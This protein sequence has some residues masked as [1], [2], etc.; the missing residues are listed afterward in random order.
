MFSSTVLDLATGLVFCFLTASLSTGVVVEAISSITKWRAK[1]LRDGIGQLL[2]DPQLSGLAGQLYS[3]A[4]I[5]PRGPG[6]ADPEKNRPAYIDRQLFAHAMMDLTGIS[7]QVAAAAGASPGARPSLA[8]LHDEVRDKLAEMNV[9][10]PQLNILLRGIIDRS[11]GDAEKIQTELSTWFDHAMDRVSGVYKRY[12]QLIGF[13]VALILAGALNI[14]SVSVAKTLWMQPT[15]A[16]KL[17]AEQDMTAAQAIDQLSAVL[18]IGWPNGIGMKAQ[19]KKDCA[20]PSTDKA[21]CE[22]ADVVNV[23]AFGPADWG[24]ALLGW[25][26]TAFATLFGAPFW[27][28]LLQTVIRLKGSGPSPQEKFVGRGGAA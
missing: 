21:A 14:D 6:N 5:N 1:T 16:E 13:V 12:A 25:L 20:K 22:K 2:N 23:V 28:D 7:F 9:Q 3:H 8:A 10:D 17:K 11:F 15:V 4:A 18:P 19:I 26:I 24:L 27:F